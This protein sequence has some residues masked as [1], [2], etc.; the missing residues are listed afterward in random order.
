MAWWIEDANLSFPVSVRWTP[1]PPMSLAVNL[2]FTKHNLL[3][4]LHLFVIEM[5]VV[6]MV[7]V[8]VVLTVVM[9]LVFEVV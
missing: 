5:V 1:S 8:V 7:V 4:M 3:S 9:V 2:V 6:V